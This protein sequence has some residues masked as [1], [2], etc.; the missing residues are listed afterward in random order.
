MWNGSDTKI[1]FGR[2]LA[3]KVRTRSVLEKPRFT[4]VLTKRRKFVMVSILLSLGLFVIQKI[5]VEQR[6]FAIL[7]LGL[8]SYGLSAW[9][10]VKDL[11]GIAWVN[12]LILP[13]IYPVA[14]ALFYF[15]LPQELLVRMVVTVVFAISM[16]ALLLT[17][18]IFAVASIRTI[19]LLRAARVIGFLLTVLT[20]V[21]I[22]H[23][24]FS[25]KIALLPVLGLTFGVSILLF[26][27]GVW[28]HTLSVRSQQKEWIYA[29]VGAVVVTEAAMAMSFW[30]VDVAMVGIMLGM[31]VYVILG[32]FQ[33]DLDKRLFART[34]QEYLGFAGI[35]FV[36]IAIT[37]IYR[38]M[39]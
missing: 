13:T 37:V 4:T 19:Q 18:N 28:S 5:P 17:A 30:L 16:Y 35:V 25:L 26:L 2:R 27:Q 38:W 3:S 10:L 21:F 34:T 7:L 39:N 11:Y 32:L 22:F 31:M 29:L 33:Q 12:N 9:A 36:V 24:I 15:L 6:Y 23:V 1:F 20:S 8:F 14:V